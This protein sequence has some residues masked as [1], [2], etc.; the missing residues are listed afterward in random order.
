MSKSSKRPQ[1]S[2]LN[3]NIDIREVKA[4]GA[5]G[6]DPVRL[7]SLGLRLLS[8]GFCAG[9][10]PAQGQGLRGPKDLKDPGPQG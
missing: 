8:F 3:L 10:G 9:A 4:H 6:A 2:Y 7:S 5:P 1:I